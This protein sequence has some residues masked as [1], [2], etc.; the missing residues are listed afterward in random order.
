MQQ[1]IPD[2]DDHLK[3]YIDCIN[4]TVKWNEKIK[5][6]EAL[7]IE[8]PQNIQDVIKRLNINSNFLIIASEFIAVGK[9]INYSDNFLYQMF[10]IKSIYRIV[11]ETF[12][13]MNVNGKCIF[14]VNNEKTNEIKEKIKLFRKKY[15]L[16]K[17]GK[18]RNKVA[19]HYTEDFNEH[20][21]L[22]L[23][24]DSKQTM[25]MY[26]EFIELQFEISN[27]VVLDFHNG[28]VSNEFKEYFKYVE[29]ELIKIGTNKSS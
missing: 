11:Y 8:T 26:Y 16:E 7:K 25:I 17:I 28:T 3:T 24:I 22:M 23:E 10:F 27:F 9:S 20:L 6:Y 18:I 12:N 4:I 21:N 5:E 1:P 2:F 15:S 13:F 29:E 19:A 14:S